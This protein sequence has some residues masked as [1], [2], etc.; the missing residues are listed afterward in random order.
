M[1]EDSHKIDTLHRTST[2]IIKLLIS[3]TLRLGHQGS[4]VL[5]V[6]RPSQDWTHLRPTTICKSEEQIGPADVLYPDLSLFT[7]FPNNTSSDDKKV[8]TETTAGES[9]APAGKSELP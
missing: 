7:S 4:D 6:G 2:I 8:T 9:K 5:N 1:W 3:S